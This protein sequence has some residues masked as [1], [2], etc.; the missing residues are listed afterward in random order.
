MSP[1]RPIPTQRMQPVS[2]PDEQQLELMHNG[3]ERD[4]VPLNIFATMAHNPGLLR[5]INALGGRFLQRGTLGERVRE[6]AILRSSY[7]SGSIYEFG[8]HTLIGRAAGLTD[9]EITSLATEAA[10]STWS[11][12]ERRVITM[13]DELSADDI[14]SDD[15]WAGL[16]ADWDDRQLVELLLLP[17]LYRML[18]GFLNSAGVQLEADAPGWPDPVPT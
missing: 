9:D 14:V 7:R 11:E 13:V 3:M 6:I 15:T 16:R 8:Q 17:G 1:L 12:A 18:A 2:D 5:R 10:D 4:G